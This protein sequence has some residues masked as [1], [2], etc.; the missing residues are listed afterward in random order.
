MT[1]TFLHIGW[2]WTLLIVI[3]VLHASSQSYFLPFPDEHSIPNFLFTLNFS[4]SIATYL[5]KTV[6]NALIFNR[7]NTFCFNILN[8]IVLRDFY[9]SK[10]IKVLRFLPDLPTNKVVCCNFTGHWVATKKLIT[11]GTAGLMTFILS[12]VQLAPS[13]TGMM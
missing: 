10:T 4:F 8:Y 11:P 13:L 6:L 5:C 2:D 3:Y 7:N 1:T 9:I 12:W